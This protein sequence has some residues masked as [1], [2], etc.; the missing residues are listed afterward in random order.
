MQNKKF[1]FPKKEKLT[2]EI[3]I[4][5]LFEK[6]EFFLAY[7]FRIGFAIMPK[8]DVPVEVLIGVSKKRFKHA[9]DRNR[10][11]RLT[12]EVY[13]LNKE[14]LFSAAQ[15][16]DYSLHLSVNYIASEILPYQTMEKKWQ[17]TITKFISKLP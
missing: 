4:K 1:S 5:N 2:G 12:R 13:R 17:E 7:P 14:Q 9:V 3:K 11:K 10:I 16:K 8:T 15:E 6:G